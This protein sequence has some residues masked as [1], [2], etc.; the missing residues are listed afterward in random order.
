MRERKREGER[1]RE[2]ER[3][4]ERKALSSHSL[5]LSLEAC[6]A[7]RH[8]HSFIQFIFIFAY[9]VLHTPC[10]P[11]YEKMLRFVNEKVAIFLLKR[12]D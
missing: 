7:K 5:C 9:N 12:Q 10:T 8:F 3:C 6:M 11:Y 1:E 4:F 2:C